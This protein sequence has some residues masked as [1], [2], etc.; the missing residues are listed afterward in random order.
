[1]TVRERFIDN[2]DAW[3][4]APFS[5]G[6]AGVP[7]IWG[8]KD[9]A[10]G[11]DCSGCVT[12]AGELA[13]IWTAGFGVTHNAA[14][15]A[16]LLS[17]VAESELQPGDLCF[18]GPASNA[19]SHVMA[20]VG[21]GRVIGASGGDSSCTTIVIARRIGAAVHY[22]YPVSYRSDLVGFRVLC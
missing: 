19:I 9:P 20:W 5:D 4:S 8:G 2:I 16:A 6:I 14:S 17:P 10:T 13:G 21:D 3:A 11:L 7:Y 15:L 22:R 1:M 18:Y 12:A